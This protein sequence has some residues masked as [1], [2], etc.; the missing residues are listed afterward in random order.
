MNDDMGKACCCA[1]P[2]L[3][4]D[5]RPTEGREADEE[6]AAFAKALG[7]PARIQILRILSARTTCACGEIVRDLPL[8]QSTV[9]EHLRILKEAGLVVGEVTGPRVS[10]CVDPNALRRFKRL[11]AGLGPAAK[12]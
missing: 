6:L 12:E 2:E 10:Y 3:A 4:E 5:S 11:V 9:S 7:H 8:A 1:P